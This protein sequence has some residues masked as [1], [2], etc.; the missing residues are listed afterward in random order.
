[1]CCYWIKAVLHVFTPKGL[2]SSHLVTFSAEQI[3]TQKVRKQATFAVK[4]SSTSED[5]PTSMEAPTPMET[6]VHEDFA[7]DM[8]DLQIQTS[9]HSA[10]YYRW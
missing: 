9:C 10:G 1:M 7:N 4:I 5:A 2:R 8:I 6:P 3:T